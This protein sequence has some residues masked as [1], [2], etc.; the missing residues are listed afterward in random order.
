MMDSPKKSLKDWSEEELAE[1]EALGEEIT[2][3]MI[4]NLNDATSSES[5]ENDEAP[6]PEKNPSQN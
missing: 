5:S 3:E 1:H 2:Q 4:E 6:P